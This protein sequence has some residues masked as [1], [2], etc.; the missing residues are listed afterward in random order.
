MRRIKPTA[1]ARCQFPGCKEI[2]HY[3]FENQKEYREHNASRAEYLCTRHT[4]PESVLSK[5]SPKRVGV[6]MTVKKPYG[7]FWETD[8]KVTSGFVYGQGFKAYAEDFPEGTKLK[9]TAEIEIPDA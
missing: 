1:I 4:D 5:E 8:G 7:S 3:V 6:L 9:I 2:A